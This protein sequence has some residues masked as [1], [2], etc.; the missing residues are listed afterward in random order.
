[1]NGQTILIGALLWATICSIVSQAAEPVEAA[2]K[3]AKVPWDLYLAQLSQQVDCYFTIER[4]GFMPG[5]GKIPPSPFHRDD[6]TS[7][8]N[9]K[10]VES[11]VAKLRKEMK[12]VVVIE[13]AKNPAVIH[14][15]EERVL[16]IDGYVMDKKIDITYSGVLAKLPVELEKRLPEIGPFRG[17]S[18]HDMLVDYITQVKVDAKNQTVREVLTGC[19]PLKNYSPILWTAKT[20]KTDGRCKTTVG[21]AGPKS[22]PGATKE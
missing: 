15:I 4:M 22:L 3:V 1:M 19:V 8:P 11:L 6:L 14:L 18:T 17:G 21:H 20:R 13:N 9:I 10:T 16:K 5:K 7:D 12:G 2:K